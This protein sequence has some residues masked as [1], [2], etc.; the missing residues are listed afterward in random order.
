MLSIDYIYFVVPKGTVTFTRQS[1]DHLPNWDNDD[2]R[3]TGLHV[4]SEGTIED[5]GFGLLQVIIGQRQRERQSDRPRHTGRQREREKVMLGLSTQKFCVRESY[6][7]QQLR[8]FVIA[9]HSG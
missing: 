9:W 8:N 4:S 7:G 2:T 3:L 6:Q 5:D 1:L